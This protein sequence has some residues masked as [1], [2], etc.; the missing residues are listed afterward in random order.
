MTNIDFFYSDNVKNLTNKN[1]EYNNDIENLFD[2]RIKKYW[3]NNDMI[4]TYITNTD[5]LLQEFK[6]YLDQNNI[7][8]SVIELN[9]L[10]YDTY[11]DNFPIKKID[12][13]DLNNITFDKLSF[14]D[15]WKKQQELVNKLWADILPFFIPP[16]EINLKN[17]SDTEIK[18]NL[19][20][21]EQYWYDKLSEYREA[22]KE[23]YEL[24]QQIKK[25][26]SKKVINIIKDIRYKTR[27]DALNSYS[28]I[29]LKMQKNIS[30]LSEQEITI[31]NDILVRLKILYNKMYPIWIIINPITKWAYTWSD[32]K[33]KNPQQLIIV[34]K[35]HNKIYRQIISMAKFWYISSDKRKTWTSNKSIVWWDDAMQIDHIVNPYE[36]NKINNTKEIQYWTHSINK[37]REKIPEYSFKTNWWVFMSRKLFIFWW[38]W[39]KRRLAWQYL[40]WANYTS[41]WRPSS[42]S[43]IRVPWMGIW[44][45]SQ[46]TKE[47]IT[48]KIDDNWYYYEVDN[49]LWNVYDD[50]TNHNW[51]TWFYVL[52]P[53][54][55]WY[56]YNKAT[57]SFEK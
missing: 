43:C 53:E 52:D 17:N 40:H 32:P 8:S 11:L 31:L 57:L 10:K 33:L 27:E 38:D 7:D 37:H 36:D 23:K 6:K 51:G 46:F 13:I 2:I 21:E 15:L 3:K 56:T 26:Q 35:V 30:T 18:N 55:F 50:N 54:Y 9:N 12:N 5:Y 19:T 14:D 45:L 49:T 1:D 48:Y 25:I 47:A 41:W 22:T 28:V 42:A 20:N 4:K 34:D 39:W 16:L 24:N 29:N 44:F